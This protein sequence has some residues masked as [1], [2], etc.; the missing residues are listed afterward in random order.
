MAQQ[1]FG[2]TGLHCKSCVATVTEALEALPGVSAVQVDLDPNGASQVRVEAAGELSSEQVQ[3]ALVRLVGG[4]V[5][6]MGVIREPAE[7]AALATETGVPIDAYRRIVQTVQKREY[8]RKE[9]R[10]LVPQELG[11]GLD[12]LQLLLERSDLLALALDHRLVLGVPTP[13]LWEGPGEGSRLSHSL[14]VLSASA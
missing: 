2:V 8:V 6:V 9:G 3:A 5:A 7:I 10:A 13:T 1:I 11:L 14:R 12:R 4:R